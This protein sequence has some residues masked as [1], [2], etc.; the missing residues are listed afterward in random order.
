MYLFVFVL[1]FFFFAKCNSA[2]ISKDESCYR[3]IRIIKQLDYTGL[4]FL[5][6]YVLCFKHLRI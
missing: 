2:K 3:Y 6:R 5:L 1:F 4:G